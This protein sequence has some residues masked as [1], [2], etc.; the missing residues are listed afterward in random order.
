VEQFARSTETSARLQ[1]RCRFAPRNIPDPSA[2]DPVDAGLL[3]DG[4]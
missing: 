3:V 4:V 1:E 2:C